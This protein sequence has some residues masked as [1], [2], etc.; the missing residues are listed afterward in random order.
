MQ[1]LLRLLSI[2]AIT[3]FLL[4]DIATAKKRVVK[5]WMIAKAADPGA[6]SHILDGSQ[7]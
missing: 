6:H 2:L 7:A 3:A 5:A 4:G 1:H